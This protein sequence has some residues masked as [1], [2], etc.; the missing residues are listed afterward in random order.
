[1]PRGQLFSSS[2]VSCLLQVAA[3]LPGSQRR[4]VG[5]RVR[6]WI[7][8]QH[9]Q[10]PGNCHQVPRHPSVW[11]MEA[12]LSSLSSP[13]GPTVRVTSWSSRERRYFRRGITSAWKSHLLRSARQVRERVCPYQE[14]RE[15]FRLSGSPARFPARGLLRSIPGGGKRASTLSVSGA[16]KFPPPLMI[17]NSP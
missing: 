10:S 5:T 3:W 4:T 15:L 13:A 8:P 16:S 17:L 14:Y 11:E 6:P 2:P 1:M 12:G 7:S 9:R